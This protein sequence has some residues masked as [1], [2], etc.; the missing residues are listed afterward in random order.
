MNMVFYEDIP[1]LIK[2]MEK[3]N[4]AFDGKSPE[5]SGQYAKGYR[6]AIEDLKREIY[7]TK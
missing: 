1:E 2:F 4:K 6:D 3:V 7:E 5:A